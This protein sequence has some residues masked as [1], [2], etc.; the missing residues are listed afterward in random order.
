MTVHADRLMAGVAAELAA[1][2]AELRGIEAALAPEMARLAPIPALQGFDAL[3]QR[4]DGLALVLAAEAAH[5][6]AAALPGAQARIEALR[7]GVLAERLL[8]PGREGGA[9]PAGRGAGIE[10]F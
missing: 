10:L 5:L 4:L 6:P 2:A 8:G 9:A 7:L 3:L 1:I